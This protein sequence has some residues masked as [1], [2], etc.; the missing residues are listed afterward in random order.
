MEYEF[1]KYPS[2]IRALA[3]E[4]NRITKDYDARKIGNNELKEILLWYATKCRDKVFQ[5]EDYNPTLKKIIGKRRIKLLDTLL[6]GYQITMFEG[7][8]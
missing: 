1:L 5:G 7:V 6:D 8:K 3:E 2:S 4:M